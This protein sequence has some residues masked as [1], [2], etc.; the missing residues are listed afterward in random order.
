MRVLFVG[1][2]P[3]LRSATVQ[4]HYSGRSNRFWKLLHDAGLTQRPLT[5]LDDRHLP[6]SGFGLTNLIA[7]PTAGIEALG[8]A[9]YRAG[10]AVLRRKV[11]RFRPDVV[12]LVGVS[13]YRFLSPSSRRRPV[14]L[15][16]QRER[17][18]DRP[19]FVLPNPSGR[20]A[21]IRYNAMLRAF[22]Q[23]RDFLDGDPDGRPRSGARR[24]AAIS[25]RAMRAGWFPA[26]RRERA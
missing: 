14:R 2:N 25:S 6:R 9:E 3:G 26:I 13:I 10:E 24:G 11:R 23:L 1:I 17:F 5:C 22:R 4:H 8:T 12:A 18:E 16:L 19:L 21:G 20:N 7:R 15:G